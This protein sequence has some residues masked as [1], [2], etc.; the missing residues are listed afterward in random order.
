VCPASAWFGACCHALTA[1]ET[2]SLQQRFGSDWL[3]SLI[4]AYDSCTGAACKQELSIFTV[5]SAQLSMKCMYFTRQ[6]TD[7]SIICQYLAAHTC[8]DLASSQHARQALDKVTQWLAVYLTCR[9]A[10]AA[11]PYTRST[12]PAN[13]Q[14]LTTA[15]AADL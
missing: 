11:V 14:A 8:S 3:S 1:V 6:L 4:V 10:S 15:D 13:R 7:R 5:K 2:P 9:G 12:A